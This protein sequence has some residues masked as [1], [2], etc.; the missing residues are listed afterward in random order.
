MLYEV[1]TQSF[2]QTF[3][4]NNGASLDPVEKV[5]KGVALVLLFGY[6]SIPILIIT[7]IV[8]I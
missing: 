6:I 5:S 7:G 3:G 2:I 8:K 1:I 4:L